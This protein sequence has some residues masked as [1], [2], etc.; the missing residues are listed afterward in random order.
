MASSQHRSVPSAHGKADDDGTLWLIL[1]TDS[2]FEGLTTLYYDE[3]TV[4]LEP[5]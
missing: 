2:G 5:R 1:G 3:I 4:V